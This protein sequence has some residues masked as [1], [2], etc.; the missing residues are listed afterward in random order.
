MRSQP[1]AAGRLAGSCT[2]KKLAKELEGLSAEIAEKAQAL[3]ELFRH[4]ESAT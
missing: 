1:L 3:D 4:I 2:D